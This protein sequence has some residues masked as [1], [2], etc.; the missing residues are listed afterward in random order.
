VPPEQLVQF[1]NMVFTR[2]DRV[3]EQHG[4]EKIKTL[5]DGYVVVGGLPE[6]RADHAVAVAEMALDL[7][8]IADAIVDPEGARVQLRIGI[9]TGPVVAGV[10]GVTKLTYDVWGDTVNTASRLES[11]GVPGRIQ[12]GEACYHRLL[13]RY[14][15]EPRGE[16]QLK[17]KGGLTAYFLTGRARRTPVPF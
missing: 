12:V 6:P 2:F 1:L 5:G 14:Q 7:M 3:A 9:Q 10:I 8:S 16:I 13:G 4:L 15:L 17:G 11:H